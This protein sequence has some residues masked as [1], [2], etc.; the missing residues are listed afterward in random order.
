LYS[1][2]QILGTKEIANPG[3]DVYKAGNHGTYVMTTMAAY[4]SAKLVGSAP[5]AAYW[6]IHTEDN[7]YEYP[8]EEFNWTIG[9]EFADSAGVDIITSSLIYSTFDEPSLNHN[10]SQLDGKTAI[11]SRA[12][13][14]ATE[15]GILVFNSAGNDA[16]KPWHKIAF[17]AD[18]K[19]VMTIGAVDMQ[20]NYAKFSSV[21]YTTDNRI[22][23]DVV[24]VGKATLSISPNTGELVAINGTSFSNPTIAGATA[25]LLQANPNAS[26]EDIRQAIRQSASQ[27][28]HPDSLMGYGIPNFYLAHIL[29]NNKDLPKLKEQEGFTLMPNPFVSDL[30]IVYNVI[31]TQKVQIQVFDISG[32]LMFEES[33]INSLPGMNLYKLDKASGLSQGIYLVVLHIGNEKYT[34]KLV[35]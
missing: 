17:P 34:R 30:F 21:G 18:A 16:A 33:N 20:G 6:L 9:A 19:D 29:L 26:T 1:N 32:K 12:A 28:L 4:E 15:K 5:A 8:I 3:G 11:I 31:D 22:K 35:K 25:V 27:N 24:A 10:H 2:A 13:Q 23:P 7:S 14:T